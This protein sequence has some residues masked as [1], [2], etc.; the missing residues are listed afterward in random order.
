MNELTYYIL[1]HRT[2]PKQD[3]KAPYKQLCVNRYAELEY[4]SGRLNNYHLDYYKEPAKVVVR[5]RDA[6]DLVQKSAPD[7]AYSGR[8]SREQSAVDEVHAAE[9]AT[10]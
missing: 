4:S 9:E 1:A 8:S 6:F 3:F 2:D 10:K 7:L 5:Y